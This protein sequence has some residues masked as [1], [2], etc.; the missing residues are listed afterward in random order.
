V[1]AAGDGMFETIPRLWSP[2]GRAN[3][4]HYWQVGLAVVLFTFIAQ[5]LVFQIAVDAGPGVRRQMAMA[6]WLFVVALQWLLVASAI[7]RLHDRD[8]SGWWAI[9][10]MVVPN[11]IISVV[12]PN[13]PDGA[14]SDLSII[15]ISLDLVRSIL[16]VITAGLLVWT[17]ISLGCERGT[18]GDNRFGP[19]P[20]AAQRKP[21]T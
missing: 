1:A 14:T 9:P 12:I 15:T 10:M 2:R 3:R 20:L 11:L 4:A 21:E 6:Y 13:I 5:F 7:R 18:A 8:K 17:L 16:W 19:D